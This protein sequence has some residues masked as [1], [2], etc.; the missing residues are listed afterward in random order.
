MSYQQAQNPQVH[1]D[2]KY[3]FGIVLSLSFGVTM[4]F[5]SILYVKDL[6]MLAQLPEM[7]WYFVC[8]RPSEDGIVLPMLVLLTTAAFLVGA[9]LWGVQR[10]RSR[11][12]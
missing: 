5:F 12:A 10:V 9:G 11:R 4:L 6:Q 7:V 1:S 2:F 3:R 8:G